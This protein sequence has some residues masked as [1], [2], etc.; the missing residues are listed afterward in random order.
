VCAYG[1]DRRTTQRH[2]PR[3]AASTWRWHPGA[4]AVPGLPAPSHVES[5]GNHTAVA[6]GVTVLAHSRQSTEK[7]QRQE[8]IPKR[9]RIDRKSTHIVYDP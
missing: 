2:D 3:R 7:L 9:E 5:G 8:R 1:G 4:G 6:G